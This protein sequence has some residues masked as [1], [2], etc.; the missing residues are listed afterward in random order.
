[1]KKT[2]PFLLTVVCFFFGFSANVFAQAEK[3]QP[4]VYKDTVS[5]VL[6]GENFDQNIPLKGKGQHTCID[7]TVSEKRV[8]HIYEKDGQVTTIFLPPSE[9][10]SVSSPCQKNLLK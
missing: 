2:I 8:V 5:N 1:M 3:Q 9:V 10:I 6:L 7:F 4:K